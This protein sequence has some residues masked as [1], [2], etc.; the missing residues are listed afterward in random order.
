M[1]IV[2][3]KFLL[4]YIVL[5]RQL[6][7]TTLLATHNTMYSTVHSLCP[8]H[9]MPNNQEQSS[10]QHACNRNSVRMRRIEEEETAVIIRRHHQQRSALVKCEA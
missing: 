6:T 1:L 5:F 7:Y 3:Q 4:D 9:S 10:R 8:K 2:K